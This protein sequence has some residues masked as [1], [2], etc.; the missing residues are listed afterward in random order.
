MAFFKSPAASATI[1]DLT[2]AGDDGW[3]GDAYFLQSDPFST[4]TGVIDS[5]VQIGDARQSNDDSGVPHADIVHA[6]NTRVNKTL[7]NG[8]SNQFNHELLLGRIPIEEIDEDPYLEFLLDINQNNGL[9]EP[10][11]FLSLDEIQIFVS[12]EPNQSTEDFDEDGILELEDAELVYWMD[13][14]EDSWIKLNYALNTGSGSGDMF[15]YI[16][17]ELFEDY[18]EDEEDQY[19][20]L[21]SR[22]GENFT[23]NDGFEEW[24]IRTEPGEED[25]IPEPAT[26]SLLGLGLFGLVGSR[27]KKG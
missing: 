25:I 3:I 9:T 13:E 17:E 20:Y 5:F 18:L 7:D 19:V 1:L 27:K 4:G 21:Y 23:N 10:S 15:A 8:A 6:Y 24:A 26:I 12:S 14:E 11:H 16:P 2:T 22:F